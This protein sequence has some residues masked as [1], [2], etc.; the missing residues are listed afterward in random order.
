MGVDGEP[1]LNIENQGCLVLKLNG[2]RVVVGCGEQLNALD[3]FAFYQGEFDKAPARKRP[4]AKGK[5]TRRRRGFAGFLLFVF[6]FG[7]R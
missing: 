4:F 2:K 5:F 1:W 6:W 3:D 7:F